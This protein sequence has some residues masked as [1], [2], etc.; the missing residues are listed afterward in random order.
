MKFSKSLL[1]DSDIGNKVF[2]NSIIKAQ[3]LL[4][5]IFDLSFNGSDPRIKTYELNDDTMSFTI[6]FTMNDRLINAE[7]CY[8]D[9]Q[10][11][12]FHEVLNICEDVTEHIELTDIPKDYNNA[13]SKV[14]DILES[15]YELV[16]TPLDPN[17]VDNNIKYISGRPEND[18]LEIVFTHEDHEA[19]FTATFLFSD[20]PMLSVVQA[21]KHSI[22]LE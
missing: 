16:F 3:T 21:K 14:M 22:F 9:I 11:D 18:K 10:T 6:S 8:E 4:T 17:D 2:S 12:L 19:L 20:E 7:L 15:K 5:D 13:V 1:A